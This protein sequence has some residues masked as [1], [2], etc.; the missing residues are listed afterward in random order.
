MILALWVMALGGLGAMCRYL[1]D[2]AISALFGRHLPWGTMAIN[3]AGSGVAGLLLGITD[4]QH[5]PGTLSI[6]LLAGF[7]GGFTTASTLAFEAARLIEVRRITSAFGILI[8][9]MAAGLAAGGLGLAVGAM[10]R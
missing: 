5:R 7:L 6:A 10:L 4:Y 1:C 8:G 9:T 2:L 3:V